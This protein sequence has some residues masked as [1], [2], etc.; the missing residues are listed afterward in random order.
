MVSF[1]DTRSV[2]FVFLGVGLLIFTSLFMAL[3]PIGCGS[4]PY[5]SCLSTIDC[6]TGQICQKGQCKTKSIHSESK[7]E[8][9]SEPSNPDAGEPLFPEKM[10]EATPEST[11]ECTKDSD[12]KNDFLCRNQMCVKAPPSC[13]PNQHLAV[14]QHASSD[15]IRH[16]AVPQV[17]PLV[18]YHV[19]SRLTVVDVVTNRLVF[20]GETPFKTVQKFFWSPDGTRVAAI[21]Q[22]GHVFLWSTGKGVHSWYQKGLALSS[23]SP[24]SKFLL[25][26]QKSKQVDFVD[27]TT[28]Q[29]T[30]STMLSAS[31]KVKGSVQTWLSS[32]GK[33]VV[34]FVSKRVIVWEAVTGHVVTDFVFQTENNYFQF[35]GFLND[36]LFVLK[37]MHGPSSKLRIFSITQKSHVATL[38]HNI[39]LLSVSP[40]GAKLLYV[41]DK[42]VKVTSIH[43]PSKVTKTKIT[44]SA[45]NM[46][47]VASFH[48]GSGSIIVGFYA[49]KNTSLRSYTLSDFS[50]RMTLPR[51]GQATMR[52][53]FHPSKPLLLTTSGDG[54][55]K[56]WNLDKDSNKV[57]QP[58]HHLIHLPQSQSYSTHKTGLFFNSSWTHAVSTNSHNVSLWDVQNK[59]RITSYNEPSGNPKNPVR[60]NGIHNVAFQPNG[61]VSLFQG[62]ILQRWGFS[63]TKPALHTLTLPNKYEA[64]LVGVH[65][66]T[67]DIVTRAL[68]DA[69]NEA[70]FVWDS[71]TLT[72]KHQIHHSSLLSAAVVAHHKPW[73]VSA[74]HDKQVSVFDLNTGSRIVQ[75][76][77]L[78]G[79]G[80]LVFS[81]DD[82]YLAIRTQQVE[83]FDTNTWK[84]VQTLDVSSDIF[85]FEPKGQH[86]AI[87]TSTGDVAIY[88]LKTGK[89][90]NS[91]VS[92]GGIRSIR[93]IR[94]DGT[95]HFIAFASKLDGVAEVWSCSK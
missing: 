80:K 33:Y 77:I 93:S 60:G 59:K 89:L 69:Y 53:S 78:S 88:S 22:S 63:S 36:D 81:P 52:L 64:T 95:G 49:Q 7:Q 15:W 23:F 17:G 57:Y 75:F 85:A 39:H 79:G 19:N 37:Q 27:L 87:A 71:V 3:G 68:L 34:A 82:R 67:G 41:E 30:R 35:K 72:K 31:T 56:I 13:F 44:A 84:K 51:V 12:C 21:G 73:I 29:K 11:V 40:T 4:G 43:D 1:L 28:G 9:Y 55:A 10:K 74:N 42:E 62:H 45:A 94:Y 32:S 54:V 50:Y 83:I 6:S 46:L 76:S 92:K 14:F 91:L 61:F 5:E 38:P 86:I 2:S 24:D 58:L 47:T 8:R 65:P 25:Q 20:T 66:V 90:I 16:L 48:A 18:A 70:L 26:T